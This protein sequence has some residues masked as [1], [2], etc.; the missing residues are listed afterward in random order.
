MFADDCVL[1]MSGNNGSSIYPKI[2][3]DLDVFVEWTKMNALSLNTSKTKT[4]IFGNRQKVS[5]I[6]SASPLTILGKEV[7]FVKKYNYLG[8]LLDS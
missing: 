3:S 1:Y 4:M 5:K 2:Q 7:S 8:I 6:K